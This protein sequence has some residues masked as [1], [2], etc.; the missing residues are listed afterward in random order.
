MVFG[1]AAAL[2]CDLFDSASYALYAQ[3]GRYMT[4]SGTRRVDELDYVSCTCPVCAKHGAELKNL[5]PDERVSELAR[6][7]LYVCFAEIEGVKQKIL[8][9]NLWEHISERCRSHPNLLAGFNALVKHRKWLA[10]LDL[11][12][13]KSAFFESG[14]ES[15]GR[16]EVVN[17]R[18]RIKRVSS[19]RRIRLPVFGETPVE[20]L[21]VYPLG[22]SVFVGEDPRKK[23]HD[24]RDLDKVKAIL[25]YQF[26][27]GASGVLPAGI[28]IKRS[29]KT[30][31]IRAVYEGKNILA[32]VRASDHFIIPKEGLARRLLE[33]FVKPSLRVVLEDDEE[34]VACVR[35]GKSVFAKFVKDVDKN[36]RAGDECFVVDKDDKLVRIGTLVLS[37]E[38]IK[39]FK[40]GMVVRVR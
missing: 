5:P 28:R 6:H 37:P 32:T 35:E 17:A 18:E 22:Q 19:E 30:G 3:D 1:L 8:E 11:V 10:S 39:D 21:D 15:R 24:V 14:P 40:R 12:T 2:G 7:N 31:R 27:K 13:K 23:T 4:T 16:S 29:K 26:G 38:E 25:E 36:L 9:G 34:A 20:V 33:F